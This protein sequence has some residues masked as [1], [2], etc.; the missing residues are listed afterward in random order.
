MKGK[1]RCSEWDWPSRVNGPE[2]ALRV[3]AVRERVGGGDSEGSKV[4]YPRNINFPGHF[5]QSGKGHAHKLGS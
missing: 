3:G 2:A 5:S 4:H 1:L